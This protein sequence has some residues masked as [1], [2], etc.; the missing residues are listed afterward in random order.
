MFLFL[1]AIQI[2]YFAGILFYMFNSA[3]KGEVSN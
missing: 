3:R 1:I 2:A